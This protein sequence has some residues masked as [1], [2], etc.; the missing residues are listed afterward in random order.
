MTFGI[1]MNFTR[2]LAPTN[3]F[4]LALLLFG[5]LLNTAWAQLNRTFPPNSYQ[6]TVQ[7]IND[8]YIEIDGTTVRMAPGVLIYGPTNSTI[9]K[10]NLTTSTMVRVQFDPSGDVRRIWILNPSEIVP[11]SLWQQYFGGSFV[12]PSNATT[13]N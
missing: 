1:E 10:G 6:V 2:M 4:T 12:P 7:A 3:R 9:I 13:S 11:V 5:T 8:P